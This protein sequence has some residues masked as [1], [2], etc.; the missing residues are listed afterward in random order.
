MT[1]ENSFSFKFNFHNLSPAY[2]L[3]RYLLIKFSTNILKSLQLGHQCMCINHIL[4]T[5]LTLYSNTATKIHTV[6]CALNS[7]I[8]Y[9]DYFN[10]C[11]GYY[12]A[13]YNSV[14]DLSV[15]TKIQK[16]LIRWS[17]WDLCNTDTLGNLTNHWWFAKFYH[18]NSKYVLWHKWRE[19][20]SRNLPKVLLQQAF[21]LYSTLTLKCSLQ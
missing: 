15:M 20:T 18:P 11:Y 5:L 8:K 12:P 16:V 21:T 14:N 3:V 9:F 10:H 13:Y 4:V 7:V 1:Q 17:K 2:L 6:T 19:Q